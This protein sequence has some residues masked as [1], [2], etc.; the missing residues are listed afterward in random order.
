[1]GSAAPLPL[2]FAKGVLNA[3]LPLEA[4]INFE[5][6]SQELDSMAGE[7]L[8]VPGDVT[9]LKAMK[10][11]AY[12]VAEKFGGI[13]IVIA[14]AGTHIF[15][16][17]ENFDSA[18]YTNLMDIN[19]SGMLHCI[20]AALPSLRKSPAAQIVGVSSVAGYR[21]LPT[22]AAYGASKAAMTHFLESLRFHYEKEKMEVIIVH[23]GFVKTPLTDK[24]DFRMPFLIESDKAARII[25][26]GI[27]RSKKLI[28]FPMVF[29]WGLNLMRII[30]YPLYEFIVKKFVWKE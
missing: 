29:G 10:Q 30:P 25:C 9:D 26:N 20:E 19:F 18:E 21:G 15:T 28:R 2:S 23:P 11:N 6:L 17:P 7:C 5:A 14:N 3:P 12:L 13:D 24:N 8:V 27:E 16:K 1:M 22:A 4:K